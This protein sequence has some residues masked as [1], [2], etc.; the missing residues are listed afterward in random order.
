MYNVDTLNICINNSFLNLIFL[1]L[2]IFIRVQH[3]KV[4][5]TLK[6]PPV[7]ELSLKEPDT[8][9]LNTM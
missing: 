1:P 8:F 7:P 5:H 3:S 6:S 4:M 2:C 9:T